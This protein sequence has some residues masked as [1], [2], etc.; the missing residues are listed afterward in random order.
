MSK[1][2]DQDTKD[3]YFQELSAARK[4]AR[5]FARAATIIP[6][7]KVKSGIKKKSMLKRLFG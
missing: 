2:F 7:L 6:R 1:T 3:G 5:K 4:H